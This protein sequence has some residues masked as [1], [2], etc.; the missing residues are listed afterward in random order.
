MWKS[1]LVLA[2]LTAFAQAAAGAPTWNTYVNG[3]FGFSICYPREVLAAPESASQDGRSFHG[4]GGFEALVFTEFYN[5]DAKSIDVRKLEAEREQSSGGA[6]ISYRAAGKNWFVISGRRNERIFYQKTVLRNDQF[7][8]FEASY[9]ASAANI[10]N[11]TV[12][13]MSRCFP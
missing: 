10:W 3:R 1:A 13:K 2:M 12:S 7:I 5:I 4:A 8:N 9:Q 6:S 11:F